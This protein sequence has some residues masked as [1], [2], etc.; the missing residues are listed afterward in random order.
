[1]RTPREAFPTREETVPPL[2]SSRIRSLTGIQ[3]G[4]EMSQIFSRGRVLAGLRISFQ[5]ERKDI[6]NSFGLYTSYPH[7]Q[8][9]DVK[10]AKQAEQFLSMIIAPGEV[11]SCS[12]AFPSLC[13]I[14]FRGAEQVNRAI[15]NTLVSFR[16]N[17][18][19][20]DLHLSW[21]VLLLCP[22]YTFLKWN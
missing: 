11:I 14:S 21:S 18:K 16:I 3:Y 20:E 6:H 8:A 1:M 10:Q 4:Y 22:D 5:P 12:Q 15:L 17:S 2:T 19:R 13:V 7:F 9:L